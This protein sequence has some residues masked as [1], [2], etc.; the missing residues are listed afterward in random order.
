MRRPRYRLLS[1][2]ASPATWYGGTLTSTASSGPAPANSTV[3]ITYD[4]RCRCR[5]T[6]ALGAAAVPLV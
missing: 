2:F 4:V 6:A 1:R 5:S 3:P